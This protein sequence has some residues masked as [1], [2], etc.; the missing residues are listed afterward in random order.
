MFDIRVLNRITISDEKAR[1]G[2]NMATE[3]F[4]RKVKVNRR[5]QFQARTARDQ[6]H[7]G[8]VIFRRVH[9]NCVN[10]PVDSSCM[11]V[12]PS[13]IMEQLGSHGTDFHEI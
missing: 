11:S 5:S 7:V 12:Y 10:G 3:N 2:R 9:Q 6:H 8:E 13:V 4:D 1:Q